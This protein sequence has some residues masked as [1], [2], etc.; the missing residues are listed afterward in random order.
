MSKPGSLHV[1]VSMMYGGKSTYLIHLV[2]AL[3][4]AEKILYIN[5]ASDTRDELLSTHSNINIEAVISKYATVIKLDALED[6][7]IHMS[8]K[9][10]ESYPVICIDEGQFFPDLYEGVLHFVEDLG[11]E[12]YV[13]GLKGDYKRKR[14]GGIADLLEISDTFSTLD[15]ATLCDRCCSRGG[16]DHKYNKALFTHRVD[17]TSGQQVEIGA[18]N[19]IPVCRECY[20]FL[21]NNR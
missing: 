6:L 4:R 10:I 8:D 1:K 9:D 5:H 19:Y 2:E 14:F 11:K 17:D 13:V 16:Q 20:L 18:D 21:N 3:G 12:V 7:W 15:S